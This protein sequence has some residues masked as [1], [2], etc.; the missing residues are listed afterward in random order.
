MVRLEGVDFILL[1][2][3]FAVMA[4]GI[5]G[6]PAKPEVTFA[7]GAGLAFKAMGLLAYNSLD[8]IRKRVQRQ[9]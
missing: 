3:G 2:F 1:C 5:W 7:F 4:W 8:Y 6:F 9:P